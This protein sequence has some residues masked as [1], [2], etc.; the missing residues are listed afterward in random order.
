MVSE[1]T[2]RERDQA[3]AEKFLLKEYERLQKDIARSQQSG[4]TAVRFLLLIVGGLAGVGA[5][6]PVIGSGNQPDVSPATIQIVGWAAILIGVVAFL[7]GLYV[8]NE[9]GYRAEHIRH[10]NN[11][12]RYFKDLGPPVSNHISQTVS[13]AVPTFFPW[14]VSGRGASFGVV[15][16]LTSSASLLAAYCLRHPSDISSKINDPGELATDN[17]VV[18]A[19]IFA[20]V[21]LFHYACYYLI[22]LRWWREFKEH[23]TEGKT[24]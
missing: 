20:G 7:T 16:F 5:L 19:V 12:R 1:R 6:L 17:A 23:S 4:E 18:L 11:V 13:D 21:L 8:A 24:Q 9:A 10:L 22:G 15:A 14:P 3:L 2:S